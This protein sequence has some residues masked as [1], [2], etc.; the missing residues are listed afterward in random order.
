MHP[1]QFVKRKHT[2]SAFPSFR[3]P[4]SPTWG[5][6][7]GT[8]PQANWTSVDPAQELYEANS[9]MSSSALSLMDV[10]WPPAPPKSRYKP[11][12]WCGAGIRKA[13]FL[14]E[15][16]LWSL[17]VKTNVHFKWFASGVEPIYEKFAPG[18]LN[19]CSFL[20]SHTSSLC[21]CL[22]LQSANGMFLNTW[23]PTSSWRN[24]KQTPNWSQALLHNPGQ[25]WT[26]ILWAMDTVTPILKS[27]RPRLR[28]QP[29]HIDG[30]QQN[31]DNH[32]FM[33]T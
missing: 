10:S 16:P 28:K 19:P 6:E 30:K 29:N 22:S 4:S 13:A 27:K 26:T 15:A 9:F 24:V 1:L 31:Q 33:L 12:E 25:F 32:S 5:W 8:W 21:I 20:S 14:D 23:S 18:S 17:L 11:G 7:M 2:P 3:P